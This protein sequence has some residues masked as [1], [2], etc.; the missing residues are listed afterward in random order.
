MNDFLKFILKRL[1]AVPVTLFFI[2]LILYGVIMILPQ[3]A[4]IDLY[5]PESRSNVPGWE[6]RMREKIIETPSSG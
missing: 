5:M 4:R 6:E 3:D 2:T 1:F